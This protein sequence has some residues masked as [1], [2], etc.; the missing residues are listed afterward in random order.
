MLACG[1]WLAGSLV[2]RGEVVLAD[3][4]LP[5]DDGQGAGALGGRIGPRA[6]AGR[7]PPSDAALQRGRGGLLLALLQRRL[8]SGQLLRQGPGLALNGG[9][10][11]ALSRQ[12]LRG[13]RQLGARRSCLLGRHRL[14]ILNRLGQL[15]R[16]VRHG[17]TLLDKV[18]GKLGQVNLLLAVRPPLAA[19]RGV[20]LLQPLQQHGELRAAP[21]RQL[22]PAQPPFALPFQSGKALRG[23]VLQ[24]ALQQACAG[25]RLRHLRR[26]QLRTQARDLRRHGLHL[27]LRAVGHHTVLDAPRDGR[28]LERAQRLLLWGF[29]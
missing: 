25:G 23:A 8:H 2:G 18:L 17:V 7:L 24:V 13:F 3:A 20:A 14:S 26:R 19:A 12:S 4:V 5:V 28:V 1:G 16:G 29:P 21:L 15:R 11:L 10:P 27:V 6:G 9:A 22:R